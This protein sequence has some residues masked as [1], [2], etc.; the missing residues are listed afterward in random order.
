MILAPPPWHGRSDRI[1]TTI[2]SVR[3]LL[4]YLIRFSLLAQ[5]VLA[6][7]DI[8]RPSPL[9]DISNVL[10]GAL[11]EE[12]AESKEQANDPKLWQRLRANNF[13][14]FYETHRR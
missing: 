10:R 8:G 11:L 14:R 6:R 7:P 1:F 4:Q 2:E 13:S 3:Y 5:Q 9:V 12:A